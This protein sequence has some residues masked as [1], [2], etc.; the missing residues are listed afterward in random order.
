MLDNPVLRC[1]FSADFVCKGKYEMLMKILPD[2]VGK[3]VLESMGLPGYR[4]AVR[5]MVKTG[6]LQTP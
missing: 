1:T 5:N 3:E 2:G 6:R 4:N